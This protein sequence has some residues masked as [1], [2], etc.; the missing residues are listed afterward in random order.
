MVID[1]SKAIILVKCAFPKIKTKCFMLSSNGVKPPA[2][3]APLT[4]FY[5]GAVNVYE[6][7][8]PE[9]VLFLLLLAKVF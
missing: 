3:S 2:A 8:S 6:D 5:A 7:I 4:I 9:K 1:I